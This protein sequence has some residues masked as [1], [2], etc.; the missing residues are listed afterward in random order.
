MQIT[1]EQRRVLDSHRCVRVHK[2]DRRILE[3][4]KGPAVGDLG[5]SRL[6]ALF[7]HKDHINDDLEGAL[8]SFVVLNDAQEVLIY[9]A[10]RCGELFVKVDHEKMN[11]GHNAFVGESILRQRPIDVDKKAKALNAIKEAL[12][13]GL[14]LDD[15]RFYAV[16]KESYLSDLL[17]EPC[18][19]ISRVHEVH[20][21]VEL[22][23]FGINASARNYW[24]SLNLP[25][26]M[27]VTLFWHHIVPKLEDIREIVGCR[28]LYLFAADEDPDE[29]LVNYYRNALFINGK[30]NLSANKP[31]FD[32]NSRFLYQ[33]IATLS[34]LRTEFFASFNPDEDDEENV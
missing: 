2:I 7:R 16:K 32:Y 34:R 25:Q 17:T 22:K 5:E 33:D 30:L 18:K 11:L 28:Y 14:E 8:A 27:G 6:P 29:R 26:R 23:F 21:G 13:A 4:I 10:L 20:S 1:D 19:E 31:Y 24:K 15:F 3:T 12:E 9:F